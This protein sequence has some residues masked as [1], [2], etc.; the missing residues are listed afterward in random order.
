MTAILGLLVPLS[1]S[2]CLAPLSDI[3]ELLNA[4]FSIF[5][6]HEGSW[7]DGALGTNMKE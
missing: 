2:S 3:S 5:L 4:G 6:L 1:T 7:L